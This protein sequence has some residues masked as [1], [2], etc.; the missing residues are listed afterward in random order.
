MK[1]KIFYTTI[2]IAA[3]LFSCSK[4]EDFSSFTEEG[5]TETIEIGL[6]FRPASLRNQEIVFT[7]FDEDG[8]DLTETATFFVDETE[9]TEN[10]FSSDSEGNFEVYAT[11]TAN[12]T[13]FQ[14]ET[15]SFSVVIPKRKVAIEDHTGTWCG[16]CPRITEAIERVFDATENVSV[17]AIH[18][19]D[20]MSLDFEGLL[21]EEFEVFGF[22]TGRLNRTT[23][24]TPPY[25][26]E[27]VTAM[28]G[29]P[30]PVGIGIS[31][32]ID[33]NTINA[34]ISVSSEEALADKKLV[35][36]LVENGILADQTNYLN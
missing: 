1:L 3:V 30:S 6:V 7:L 21:R 20:E 22:P 13:S 15:G 9:L 10:S 28:A 19:N 18:N 36:Y 35:V 5:Q 27:D 16:Y 4:N 32:S 12:G 34:T 33:G 14:T 29:E 11:Y 17:V 26:V 25:E 8:T 23:N 2:L 24:W 31:S